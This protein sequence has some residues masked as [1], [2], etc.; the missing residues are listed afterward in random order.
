MPTITRRIERDDGFIARNATAEDL[1]AILHV[2]ETA[3]ERWP[4]VEL[5]RPPLEHLA[6]KMSGA[7]F[8]PD[9]HGVVEYEGK[10]IAC[11][12][13]WFARV[14][15]SGTERITD[16]GA[17][18][19]ALPEFQGRGIG[20][21]SNDL[22]ML[23]R[24]HGTVSWERPSRVASVRHMEVQHRAL[25]LR[26]WTRPLQAG[27]HL[28]AHLDHGGPLEVLRATG[29]AI[30]ARVRPSTAADVTRIERF[31]DR[32]DA[33]W[34]AARERFD[35]VRIRDAEFLNWRYADPRGGRRTI[36]AA[37]AP[38]AAGGP[39]LAYGVIR[40]ASGVLR[41]S[42]LLTHPEHPR[43]GRDILAGAVA[44]GRA[45]RARAIVAWLPPDHPDEAIYRDAGFV[46]RESF[47]VD[48]KV[49][50]GVTAPEIADQLYRVDLRRHV[51]MGD[52]DFE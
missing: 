9:A 44:L 32:A 25:E 28:R 33:L 4:A 13:R 40:A 6:W 30:A 8:G 14:W 34:E 10:V 39:L 48:Y 46:P 16:V 24:P 18:Q 41:L 45:R 36:L 17:D 21:L 20:R 11:K 23:E 35:L 2:L 26:A 42:D 15:L 37:F 31:D 5:D 38:G 51:T 49:P 50:R 43:A 7:G 47:P 19:A 22:E 1:P 3:F 12:L 29:S 27:S 52:F